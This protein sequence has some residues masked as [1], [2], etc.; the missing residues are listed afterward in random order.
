MFS[1]FQVSQLP[2]NMYYL[3]MPPVYQALSSVCRRQKLTAKID[4]K[5]N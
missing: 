3:Q 1:Q 2:G 5:K 4:D